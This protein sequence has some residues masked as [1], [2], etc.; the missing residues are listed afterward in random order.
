L[1]EYDNQEKYVSCKS[2]KE[3]GNCIMIRIRPCK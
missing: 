3:P 1:I 2:S